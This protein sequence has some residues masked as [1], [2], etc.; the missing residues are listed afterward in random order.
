MAEKDYY[1][2]LGVSKDASDTEIKSAYRKLAKK[3]HPD[4]NQGN[5]AAASKFKE[6]N[7]AYETL[8]D[9]KKRAEYD[10]PTPQGFNFGGFGGDGGG[11]GDIFGDIFNSFTGG[12][13]RSTQTRNQQGTDIYVDLDLTFEEACK[14]VHKDIKIRK[15]ERCKSCK[16]T[17]AKNGSSYETCS[18]C[19]GT[20]QVQHVSN[21][22]FGQSVSYTTCP[23]CGGTGRKIIEKCPNCKG[24][25]F[26]ITNRTIGIDIPAGVDDGNQLSVRGRG[27]DAKSANAVAGDLILNV[28]VRS[29]KLLKRRG[30]DLFVELPV[31]FVTAT[32]GGTIE[33]PTLD[34][35]IS[36]KIPPATQS[37]TMLRIR[38]KGIHLRNGRK[39]DLFLNVSIEVPKNLSKKQ[40]KVL[41]EIDEAFERKQYNKYKK[42]MDAISELAQQ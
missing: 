11:F 39:G 32:L 23:E 37:G 33:V 18:H 4:L 29:H 28:R 31:P 7:E 35:T 1:N 8:S 5:E 26:T 3:Y 15:K 16:G 22:I 24:A 2:I 19:H 36:Q 13:S 20:G 30:L 17:G 10:N 25:G 38:G 6:V 14:G 41:K 12:Y 34:G 40:Q 9:S 27:N 42:Y 21:T